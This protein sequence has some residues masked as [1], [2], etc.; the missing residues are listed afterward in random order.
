MH[1]CL[2]GIGG[3]FIRGLAGIR[4]DQAFPGYQ[5]TIIKPAVL[6]DLEWANGYHDSP[7]GRISCSWK[8]REELLE[9]QISVPANSSATVYLPAS[10]ASM[11]T[12]GGNLSP[13]SVTF[14]RKENGQAVYHVGS[15]DYLFA[16]SE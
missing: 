7:Y 5:H 15:G 8:K 9:V 2:N 3:W 10:D 16:V 12:E 1:G 11:V 13:D 14:L 4:P 6:D